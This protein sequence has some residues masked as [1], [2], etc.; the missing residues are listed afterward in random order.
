MPHLQLGKVFLFDSNMINW[1]NII[2]EQIGSYF[3]YSLCV[4]DVDGDNLDDSIVGAPMYNDPNSERNYESGRVYIL[5]Q[6]AY[7]SN[8]RDSG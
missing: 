1:R 5:F 6:D 8:T 3:G 7:V 4:V 2:G